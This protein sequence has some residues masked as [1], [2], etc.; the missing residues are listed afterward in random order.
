M[1]KGLDALGTAEKY[2]ENAKIKNRDPTLSVPSKTIPGAQNM[3]KRHD[4][5]VPPKIILRPQNMKTGPDALGTA[6]N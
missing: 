3:K 5:G 4:A 1:K 6:E 2:F